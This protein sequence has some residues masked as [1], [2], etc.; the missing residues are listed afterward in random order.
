MEPHDYLTEDEQRSNAKLVNRMKD[1]NDDIQRLAEKDNFTDDDTRDFEELGAEFTQ[2]ETEHKRLHREAKAR[3]IRTASRQPGAVLPGDMRELD[4]DPFTEPT[5]NRGVFNDPWALDEMR[6]YPLDSGAR[7]GELRARALSAIEKMSG[8][9]DH[10]REVMTAMIEQSDDE[11]GTLAQQALLTSSPAYMRAF[12]KAAKGMTA[13]QTPEEQQA[14]QRA[15]SLTD[16]EGG[17]LVPFQLDPTVIITSDG[18]LNEIRRAARA[19]VATGDAW[20]GVSAGATSWSWDAEAAEVSD[21]A[22]TFAQPS[23]PIYKGAGFIPISI[24]AFQDEANVA[25]EVG[26][27]LAFGKD[28]L[29]SVAFATGTGSGQPTGIVTALSG[30]APPVVAATTNNSFGLEDI[31]LLDSALPARYRLNASWLAHRNTYN[32]TRQ[33]D[34]SGGAALWTTL[35]N[36]VPANLLGKPA[37]EAEGMDSA[38]ATGD[39]Y[40]LIYGDFS[41]YVI[42][43]RVGTT[44]EFIPHLFGTNHRPTGQRGWYAY[45]RVGSDSLN[46]AA[47]KML[48]V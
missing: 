26:R 30:A 21:D 35:G 14:V 13:A 12:A 18:S 17:Y 27:L 24:E 47:F 37:Y 32:L 25:T 48:N 6:A 3:Y 46:D 41:N 7:A 44:V 29:E 11:K 40:V 15:M 16:S 4:D 10:R 1:I 36:D 39:D 38:I 34:T 2:L 19:V 23:I 5:E 45:F 20:N 31:Y 43:D 9:N 33:F 8:T 22:S 42:A 28:T